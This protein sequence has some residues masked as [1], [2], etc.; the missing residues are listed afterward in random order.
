[1]LYSFENKVKNLLFESVTL[2]AVIDAINNKK[3]VKLNYMGDDNSPNGERIIE[4]YLIGKTTANNLAIRA[5]ETE[6]Y[7]KTFV[8]DWKIFLLDKIT[9]WEVL[10][11]NFEIRT[12]YNQY[13]DKSFSQ[14]TAKI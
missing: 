12:N 13:G 4:P 3:M 5:F 6:G 9:N 11:Q 7:T 10:D 1:M 2:S 8:P 14:I